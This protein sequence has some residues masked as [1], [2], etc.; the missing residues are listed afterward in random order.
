MNWNAIG[1]VV[2]VLAGAA[3]LFGLAQGFGAALYVAIPAGVAAYAVL[4]AGFAY[5][6][7]TNGPAK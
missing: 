7:A 4:R 2:A 3:V 1:R 6:A 5:L